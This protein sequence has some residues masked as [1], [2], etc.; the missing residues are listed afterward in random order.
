MQVVNELNANLEFGNLVYHNSN[1]N[2]LFVSKKRCH[3]TANLA[4]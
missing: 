2:R 4:R 1:I 3:S